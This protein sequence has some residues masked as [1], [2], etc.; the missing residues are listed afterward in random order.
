M[1]IGPEHGSL[2]LHTGVEGRAA[3]AGHAL[4]ISMN[5]WSG[6]V[7]LDGAEP[8]AVSFRT[9]LSSLKVVS[10]EGG[11]KPL[12]D[13]DRRTIESSALDTLSANKHPEV[14]FESRSI[15]SRDGGYDI[16]G[17]LK[18]A[19]STATVTAALDVQHDGGT[20]KVET[21]VPIVQTALGI[22]PY[23]GLMGGLRV[24]DRVDVHLSVT[25]PEPQ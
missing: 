7:T 25:V 20:A 4:T 16:E 23:T 1:T 21:T 2:T 17:E 6:T 24:R 19:G 5:E 8:T 15:R 22:K 14:T 9:P 12:T 18:V 3:K 10:G 13:K 11:V